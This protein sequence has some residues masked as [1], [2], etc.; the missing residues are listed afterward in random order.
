MSVE[1]SFHPT[2]SVVLLVKKS[3]GAVVAPEAWYWQCSKRRCW[4]CGNCEKY[5]TVKVHAG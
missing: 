1:V 2:C 4:Q 3:A 5:Q